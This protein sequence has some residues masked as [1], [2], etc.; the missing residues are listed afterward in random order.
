MWLSNGTTQTWITFD[1]GSVQTITGFHL[2]NYNESAAGDF[3][4]GVKTAGMYVGNSLLAQNS[5]YAAGGAAWGTL[6]QN[7][8]FNEANGLT[9]Y[10]GSDYSFTTPVTTRYLQIYATSNFGGDLYTGIAEIGFYGAGGLPSTSPVQLASGANLDLA[11]NS[12]TVASLADGTG[13][14]GAVINSA[15][16][17]PVTLTLSASSGST[18]FSG[19]ISDSGSANAISLLKSGAST[20]T[21]AG[22]NSYSGTTT[23]AGGTLTIGT[24]SLG[25]AG[26]VTFTGGTLRYAS[27]NTQTIASRIKNSTAAVTIDTNG[28]NVVF[29]S[30]LDA[31]NS[32]G[33][34]KAG[35]G[36]LSLG[37]TSA[38]SG[39]TIVSGGTLK[40]GGSY[41]VPTADSSQSDYTPDGRLAIHAI[42]GTGMSATASPAATTTSTIP[43]GTMWLSNNTSQ[44]WITFDLGSVQT[45]TGFHLWNYNESTSGLFARARGIKTAGVYVG[46]SLLAGGSSYASAGPAWGTLAQ[47]ITLNAANGLSTYAGNDYS[48]AS[49]VTTR[50]IQLY[51]TGNFAG[52]NSYTGISEIGFYNNTGNLPS[53]TAVQIATGATLDLSGNSQTV[54]S[55]ADGIGGGGSIINNAS[56]LPATL[57]LNPAS[58]STTFSGAISDNGVANAISLV[59]AGAGTQV[60]AGNNTYTGTTTINAGTLQ[61]GGAGV[62]GGGNY[63]AAISNSGALVFSTSASQTLSGAISGGGSLSQQGSGTLT[64]TAANNYN[65]ATTVSGGVLVLDHS[66]ANLGALSATAVSIGA[67][68]T[69]RIKGN[70]GIASGGSLA[71]TASGAQISLLDGAINTFSVGGGITFAA[72]SVLSLD[73][74]ATSGMN[75][76]IAAS[77]T[78]SIGGVGMINIAGATITSGNYTVATASGGFTPGGGDFAIGTHPNGHFSFSFTNSTATAEILTITAPPFAATTYWTGTASAAA[79]DAAN[80]WSTG[81]SNSNWSTDSA[82]AH[83]ANQVPGG[84]TDVVFAASNA[85]PSSGGTLTTQLDGGFTIKGLTIAVPTMSPTQVTS[86]VINPNGNPLTLGADGLTL[87]ATS[88]SSAT[89]GGG[90]I[91]LGGSQNWANNHATLGLTVNA[92]IAASSGATTLTL[93]GTGA[94]GVTLSGAISDGGGT[95][96]LVVNQAGVTLLSGTNTYSGGTT[97]SSGTLRLGSSASLPS[98]GPVAV[99][100]TL[101]LNTYSPSVGALSGSGTID[102]LAGGTPT[103]TLGAS[104]SSGT[105]AGTLQNSAGTLALLKAGSGNIS[106]TGTSTYSGGTTIGAGILGVN[107]D[108][109]LGASSSGVTFSGNSTLQAVADNILLGASRGLTINNGVVGTIDTQSFTTTVAGVIGGGGGLA[110]AG[111]G[112]LILTGSKNYSGGTTVNVGSL[113]LGD[114]A[115]SIGSV[116]GN[117]VNNATVNFANPSAQ[118][119]SGAV[120]GGGTFQKSGAGTLLLTGINTY[121][122]PSVISGGVL[123]VTALGSSNV[124]IANGSF[125]APTQTT[126]QY[127]TAMTTAQQ[128]A[129]VW[130]AGGNASVG[131]PAIVRTGWGYSTPYPDGGQV[132]SIQKDASISQTV[133]FPTAGTYQLFWAAELRPGYVSNPINVQLDGSTINTFNDINQANW[134]SYGLVFNV[135]TA[136]QSHDRIR[137]DRHRQ[138]S[139]G[140]LG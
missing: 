58:G 19:T 135:A 50:Y 37:G 21:L 118:T 127:Y 64:L 120:S 76:Q 92:N 116:S 44:T 67:G 40:L 73:I 30:P 53:T 115:S 134:T 75:D 71:T 131:G 89:I 102:T 26:N 82:G 109:A 24:G 27:G 20:Q 101:D 54:A 16:G 45:L 140:R 68:G 43:G 126:F 79:A 49:P 83:D 7:F 70:T 51:V 122:G 22:V 33:L 52:S 123:R 138:R 110:K 57:T 85:V 106:L 47:N 105:F 13:G 4:R 88:R 60:L 28:N 95:L 66:G 34:T 86:T 100:G 133:N 72:G 29:P 5:S 77:G 46:S 8:T 108:A 55:L 124:A 90:S 98:G 94:G 84:I 42:D 48:F 121:T 59:Q 132:V 80:N 56:A 62:L 61:I 129:F 36:T 2:W 113:Q 139:N 18:S 38:Y 81:S 128:Q 31:S 117:I 15:T 103:L 104:N 130:T 41:I 91:A 63:S 23:V 99:N 25:S 9:T 125:E 114:G 39:T 137:G 3:S 119:F 69:L 35:A 10:A 14:G 78:A 96:A 97:V 93:N 12:Q 111:S 136:R 74:G 65:G 1:L 107:A 6:A 17:T 87:A 112:T 32:G 11:G